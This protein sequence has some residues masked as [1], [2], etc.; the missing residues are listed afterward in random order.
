MK[1]CGCLIRPFIIVS[2]LVFCVAPALVAANIDVEMRLN[3][4]GFVSFDHFK[5]V[6]C[7]YNRGFMKPDVSIFGILEIMGE[8]FFWPSFATEV[9]FRV[10]DIESGESILPFLEFDFPDIDE[11]IPF[12]PVVFWGAWF[13]DMQTWNC[14]FQNFWLGHEHKW[15]PSP[16]NTPTPAPTPTPM[17][18]QGDLFSIE[19]IVGNMR[20]ISAG[21][22]TQGSPDSEPCREAGEGLQF[23]HTLTKNIAVMETEVSRQMWALLE[24][25]QPTLSNDPSYDLTSPGPNYPVQNNTWYESVLFANLLSLQNGFPQCYYKDP[26]F[27]TPVDA[28]NYDIDDII[29]CKFVADGY[30]LP[31]EGEWEYFARAGTTGPF[32]CDE[33]YYN[34]TNCGSS[35]SGLLQTLEKHCVYQIG[36]HYRAKPVGS[37]LPN[38]WNLK[39]VHGNVDEWC[40][41]RHSYI[42][43]EGTV[44]DYRGS[45]FRSHRVYRGGSWYSSPGLCRS[46]RR[47]DD[48]SP[49]YGHSYVGLRLVRTIQT[50][51]TPTVTPTIEGTSTP[52]NTPTPHPP[53]QTPTPYPTDTPTPTPTHTPGNLFY[54]DPIVGN[55][56]LI[57]AGM[58]TQ[59]SPNTELCRGD[60]EG[61]QFTHY[62]TREIAMMETEVSRQMWANLKEAQPTL[63]YDRTHK[64]YS[65][66][67]SH[68]V[69]QTTWYRAVLFANLLSLENGFTQCYYKDAA[70]TTIVD[71]TNYDIDNQIYCDFAADG[72]RLPTEAEWEYA[73]RAG[74]TGLFVCIETNYNSGNCLSCSSGTHQALE[75]YCVYCGNAAEQTEVVGSKL[76]NSWDL[77]D[78]HGNVQEWC[79]DWYADYP[80][81]TM[82]DYVGPSSGSAR[83]VRGGG[84]QSPAKACRSANRD[85]YSPTIAFINLGFRL[86]RA[87]SP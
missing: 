36:S 8:Y 79:W 28:T 1:R 15:T 48:V 58:F 31:T 74:T 20:F 84:W 80:T 32:S 61:P 81:G 12:G 46:A 66:T 10:L 53:T 37:K 19:P 38:P 75:Q 68:P 29:H 42:Y 3:D 55:M 65:P 39:D 45:P 40:W 54:T 60:N 83:V 59:G 18:P 86:V 71:A 49:K 73:C 22:F 23:V 35:S 87:V 77:F 43:P 67:I 17:Y 72:Y 30:R 11:F 44:I 56:M 76:P 34:N 2:A 27:T 85:Y 64:T 25:A 6:L 16:T 24:A 41:D 14:D 26:Y 70:F 5:A 78:M 4:A 13:M 51:E 52:T 47:G 7:L 33:P 63:T 69:Q 21:T 62:L 9:D 82:S 50:L 57:P